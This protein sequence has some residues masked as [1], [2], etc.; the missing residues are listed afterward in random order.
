MSFFVNDN[1]VNCRAT[2]SKSYI[3]AI[4]ADTTVVP[5]ESDDP[6]Y[7]EGKS[8]DAWFMTSLMGEL[9]KAF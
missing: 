1:D 9:D 2:T 7:F 8:D 5:V 4:T 6:D 3:D